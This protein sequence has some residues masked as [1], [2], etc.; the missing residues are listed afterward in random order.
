MQVERCCVC[1]GT[2]F[3]AHS[4]GREEALDVNAIG[5]SR[6][7]LNV[8]DILRCR[9]C[10]FAFSRKRPSEDVLEQLYREMRIEAYEA[11][12]AS[13]LKTAGKHQRILHKYAR[14]PGRLLDIGCASGSFLR[15]SCD[16]GW[17]C[18]GVEPSRL[19][20]DRAELLLKGR[21]RL[22][23]CTLQ[24]A[25]I[26]TGSCHVVT[27][28]DVLEHVPHPLQFL[29][30]ATSLLVKG[31]ML[32]I[33]VPNFDS[34]QA[35]LLKRSWPLLLP[36]HL[37]YFNRESL[38]RLAESAGL[39]LVKFGQ[40]PATFSLNYI[41]HRMNEH[42][43]PGASLLKRFFSQSCVGQWRLPIFMGE[44]YSVWTN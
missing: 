22:L 24:Q 44:I 19:L 43:V 18:I 9:V 13:R 21:A 32:L 41:L 34:I 38:R 7:N 35:R 42:G 40:R 23:H 3:L 25:S 20:C 27:M 6:T 39:K 12:A 16:A 33:N 10:G 37:N 11:E 1:G 4:K 29:Q 28:W 17:E 36:E 5:S 14:P 31:G 8:G 26:E 15:L 2:D 30:R